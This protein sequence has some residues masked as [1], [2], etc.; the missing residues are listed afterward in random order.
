M[1]RIGEGV[2]ERGRIEAQ[3]DDA[4]RAA[5]KMAELSGE[6]LEYLDIFTYDPHWLRALPNGGLDRLPKCCK[7]KSL[8]P[9]EKK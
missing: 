4:R 9:K 1:A 3:Q 2:G 8:K 7:P 6:P 5:E